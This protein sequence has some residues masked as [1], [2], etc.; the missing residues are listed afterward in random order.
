MASTRKN[1]NPKG[2]TPTE[3]HVFYEF[4]ADLLAGRANGGISATRCYEVR[5]PNG[6][7]IRLE[8]DDP[9]G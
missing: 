9:Q 2:Q 3:V 7:L 4:M 5:N 1:Y 6:K 8:Y